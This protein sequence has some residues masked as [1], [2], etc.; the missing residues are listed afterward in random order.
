MAEL[1]YNPAIEKTEAHFPNTDSSHGRRLSKTDE[2]ELLPMA[3]RRAITSPTRAISN[4][5]P[6][7]AKNSST[8][9]YGAISAPEPR[10]NLPT[11]NYVLNGNYVSMRNCPIRKGHN[12]IRKRQLIKTPASKSVMCNS[13]PSPAP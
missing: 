7:S 13:T 6:W 5:I 4:A 1:F 8:T 11:R 10:M 3:S 2:D 12:P 9:I